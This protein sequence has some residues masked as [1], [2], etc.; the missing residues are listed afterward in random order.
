MAQPPAQSS[1]KLNDL[2]ILV[3]RSDLRAISNS[4]LRLSSRWNSRKFFRCRKRVTVEAVPRQLGETILY[5]PPPSEA[6]DGTGLVP[7]EYIMIDPQKHSN[8]IV[9]ADD[10][11]DIQF[12]G[13]SATPKDGASWADNEILMYSLSEGAEPNDSSIDLD[14]EQFLLKNDLT[15]VQLLKKSQTAE[16]NESTP[17]TPTPRKPEPKPSTTQPAARS[18]FSGLTAQI[19]MLPSPSDSVFIHYDPVVDGL[20]GGSEPNTYTSIHAGKSLYM[21]HEK[22]LCTPNP[23][24]IRIRFTIME[25]D[26]I[27]DLQAKGVA[28]IDQIGNYVSSTSFAVPY[29]DILGKAFTMASFLGKSG[30]KHYSK[31]DH[32]L[33]RDYRFLL[34]ETDD[35]VDVE[36]N[37]RKDTDHH[38]YGDYLQV[39]YL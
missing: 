15:D 22:T 32:V 28:S 8:S 29:I 4:G 23:C 26:K 39:S 9:R 31:P 14:D 21:R 16:L 1:T 30:L 25:I 35:H 11:F 6:P 13:F 3:H 27:T 18:L 33:S 34:A 20:D 24:S 37:G 12:V 2:S 7:T 19:G 10:N 17:S 36:G 38:Q 5:A